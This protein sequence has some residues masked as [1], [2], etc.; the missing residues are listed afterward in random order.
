M[1]GY[2]LTQYPRT[3]PPAGVLEDGIDRDV[4]KRRIVDM[5][6]H[7]VN[8]TSKPGIPY[9]LLGNCNEDILRENFPLILDVTMR[10]LELLCSADPEHVKTLTPTELVQQGYCDPVRVFIK[11]EPHSVRKQKS[12]RWRLIF[13]VSMPDQLIERI[14]SSK[15]NKTEIASWQDIPSAPGIGLSDDTQLAS[16]Y[17][18]VVS[19]IGDGAGAEADVTGWDWSVK[20]WELLAEADLRVRL[21]GMTGY[22]S[23]LVHNRFLCVSRSVYAMPDG[24]LLTL[25]GNGVQLSGCYNTSSTNSRL[26]VMVA[27]LVGARWA[28]AMGDDCVEEYVADAQEKYRELGHPLKMYEKRRDHFEFC[29]NLFT[30]QGTWPVDGTKTLY[31]LLEQKKITPEFLVQFRMEMRNSPRLGEFL[32]SAARVA[33]AADPEPAGGQSVTLNAG[34]RKTKTTS[35]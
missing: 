13:A 17:D 5:V 25:V 20:E 34:E 27:Y 14:F 10:R 11:D 16:L 1:K 8:R 22:Q 12:K 30:A 2:L 9:V 7:E 6:N 23:N 21:G 35:P 4:I 32:E 18:R 33:N 28:V 29:S 3:K 15:Q 24:N 31:N 26:R 19:L